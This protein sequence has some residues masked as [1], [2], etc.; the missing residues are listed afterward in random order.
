MTKQTAINP[1]QLSRWT[2]LVGYF[3][4]MAGFYLWHL[5]L[6]PLEKHLISIILLLQLGPLMFPLFGLLKGKVYTHAWS[7]YLAIYYFI[8]GVW[9]A[10]A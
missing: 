6:H 2:T 1:I 4:L 3:S 9:Y 10:G 7:M 5:W 8:V